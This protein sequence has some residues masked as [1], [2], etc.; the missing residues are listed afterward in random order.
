MSVEVNRSYWNFSKNSLEKERTATKISA[1]PSK[2]NPLR[3]FGHCAY[4]SLRYDQ[5]EKMQRKEAKT[6]LFEFNEVFYNHK[7]IY[8]S[9][10]I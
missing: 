2:R 3:R 7:R 1:I 6:V 8:S 9:L 5:A 4:A 10:G